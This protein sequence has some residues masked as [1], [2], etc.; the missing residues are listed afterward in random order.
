MVNCPKF[1][2]AAALIAILEGQ[3]F[4]RATLDSASSYMGLYG[5]IQWPGLGNLPVKTSPS[6]GARHSLEVYLWCSRV[7]GLAQGIYHYRPDR[8][9]LELLKAGRVADRWRGCAAIRTGFETV[10]YCS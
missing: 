6:G 9:E 8:H 7:D 5:H 1:C 10:Q 3:G 4:A 2:S